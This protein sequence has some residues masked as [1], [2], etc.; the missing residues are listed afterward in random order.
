M[1]D[2]D[3]LSPRWLPCA[4]NSPS[5]MRSESKLSRPSQIIPFKRSQ[6]IPT[7]SSESPQ[8]DWRNILMDG[9][10][11]SGGCISGTVGGCGRMM[12]FLSLRAKPMKWAICD[13]IMPGYRCIRG[14]K[15]ARGISLI[16][17]MYG[18]TGWTGWTGLVGISNIETSSRRETSIQV[19][20]YHGSASNDG[21]AWDNPS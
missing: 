1:N 21:G 8:L 6:H 18:W 11:I 7:P 19:E 17:V 20:A 16:Q 12:S 15:S 4:Q 14:S 5:S 2:C 9:G 3:E 10:R 13:S